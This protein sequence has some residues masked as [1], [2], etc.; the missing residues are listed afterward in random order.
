M[1]LKVVA[2]DIKTIIDATASVAPGT[3][4][5]PQLECTHIDVADGLVMFASTNQHESVR[6]FFDGE[7]ECEPGQ[8]YLPSANLLRVVKEAGKGEIEIAWNGKSQKASIRLGGTVVKLPVEDPNNLPEIPRFKPGRPFIT[9]PGSAL[10]GLF[11]RTR[12]SVMTDF[13]A[14]ALGGVNLTVKGDLI[15]AAAT[16]GKRISVVKLPI[17][18][19][20]KLDVSAILPPISNTNVK[21]LMKDKEDAVDLQLTRSRFLLRGPRGELTQGLIAGT[22]PDYAGHVAQRHPKSMEVERRPLIA[23]FNRATIIKVISEV[24]Y[25]FFLRAGEI[26]M[27]ASAGVDGEVTAVLPVPW[28]WPDMAI[29]F[30]PT[31]L[32]DALSAMK[33]EFVILGFDT[34]QS[35]VLLTEISEEFDNH[36]AASPRFE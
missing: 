36:F 25:K 12:F 1:K 22:F 30:D 8:V 4:K 9:L 15:E 3:G 32:V 35:T 20:G 2:S 5:K 34:P 13:S 24:K 19:T 31:L 7:M 21:W 16:D 10:T 29:P 23:F 6:L 33:S 26:E 11:S 14:R 18:N 17:V 28:T 27:Q